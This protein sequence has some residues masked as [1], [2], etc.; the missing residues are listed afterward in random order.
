M[1]RYITL[2]LAL[3]SLGLYSQDVLLEIEDDRISL[4]EF[5]HIFNKNNDN[6]KIDKE[7]QTQTSL[8]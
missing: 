8:R 2:I 7:Y 5:K 4:E 6:E 3:L 1:K